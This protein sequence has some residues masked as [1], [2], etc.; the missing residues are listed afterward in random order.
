MENTFSSMLEIIGINPFVFVPEEILQRIFLAAGKTKGPVPIRGTVNGTPYRQTLVKYA[1][2]WR[3][4]INLSML[5][6]SPKRIGETIE[7]SVAFDPEPRTI[8]PHPKFL[9]ALDENPQAR[10]AFDALP[11]Y[12][13]LEII[14]HFT[15]LKTEATLER[16]VA[17]AIDFLTGKRRFVGRDPK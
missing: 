9:E 6:N 10:A 14:R 3:L 5:P 4:Y 15:F 2:A 11:P 13:K 16:N 1:G 7:V 12:R 17:K 8:E